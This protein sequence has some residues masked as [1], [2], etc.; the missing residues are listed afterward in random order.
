MRDHSSYA[1]TRG[2]ASRGKGRSS[3]AKSKVTPWARYELASESVRPRSSSCVIF[4]NAWYSSRYASRD[5]AASPGVAGTPNISS[6][7]GMPDAVLRGA[8]VEP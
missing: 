1:I 4:A 8:N 3:P 6:Y 2:T 7:A 5:G